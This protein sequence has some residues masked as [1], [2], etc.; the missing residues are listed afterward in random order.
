[1]AGVE[2][3]IAEDDEVL[4]RGDN[5]TR[6]LADDGRTLVWRELVEQGW[7]I[8]IFPEGERTLTGDVSRFLPALD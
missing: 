5:V 3:R 6:G 1:M 4:V 7:S 8:L 2:L